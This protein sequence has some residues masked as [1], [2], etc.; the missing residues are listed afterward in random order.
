MVYDD[1]ITS[2]RLPF[3]TR[4]SSDLTV[5]GKVQAYQSKNVLGTNLST[6][7]VTAYTVNNG[8]SDGN[9]TVIQHTVAR[10]ITKATLDIYAVTQTKV[11]D[12]T[13]T[14]SGVPTVSGLQGS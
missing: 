4:R 6:L 14:S 2:S 8:N 10:T 5:T 12:G 3:P 7:E 9:Y 11:Y 1:T 13:I